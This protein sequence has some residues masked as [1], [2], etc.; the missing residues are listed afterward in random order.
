MRQLKYFKLKRW[1]AAANRAVREARRVGLWSLDQFDAFRPYP[2][3]MA[4]I[5][6]QEPVDS[7]ACGGGD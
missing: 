2:A 6:S 7:N 3:E 1:I 4:H 5:K